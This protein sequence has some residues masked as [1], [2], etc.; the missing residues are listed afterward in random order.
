MTGGKFDPCHEVRVFARVF[1]DAPRIDS[2]RPTALERLRPY[3]RPQFFAYEARDLFR[4]LT[5]FRRERREPAVALAVGKGL[6]WAQGFASSPFDGRD[7][8]SIAA[9]LR[10]E[11]ASG[12][13]WVVRQACAAIRYGTLIQAE[14]AAAFLVKDRPRSVAI[15]DACSAAPLPRRADIARWMSHEVL[16]AAAGWTEIE[17]LGRVTPVSRLLVAVAEH[18]VTSRSEGLARDMLRLLRR[19][20]ASED[21]GRVAASLRALAALGWLPARQ[22][23]AIRLARHRHWIVREAAV[24]T[25][26]RY[27]GPEARE[28]ALA[29]RADP[30]EHVR[31]AALQALLRL[32][33]RRILTL[34]RHALSDSNDRVTRRATAILRLRLGAERMR[35]QFLL[36]LLREHPREPER[37]L[38][39]GWPRGLGLELIRQLLRARDPAVRCRA[40]SLWIA[41]EGDPAALDP[42][43]SDP[44]GTV[45][46]AALN[47]R[48]CSLPEDARGALI[49][50][51]LEDP[52]P[53]TRRLVVEKWL[54]RGEYTDL[55]RLVRAMR[56]PAE[57]VRGAAL[58]RLEDHVRRNPRVFEAVLEA[59]ADPDDYLAEYARI[60]VSRVSLSRGSRW[61]SLRHASK[62]SN[63]PPHPKLDRVASALAWGAAAGRDL[64]QR[65]IRIVALH[66]GLGRTRRASKGG[67]IT[68]EVCL[69]PIFDDHPQAEDIVRG[70]ILHELGHHRYDFRSR[71][72]RSALGIARRE[73]LGHLYGILLDARLE[74]RLRA[75]NSEWA[76]YID[77][78]NAYAFREV[79]LQQPVSAV[80]QSLGGP[81][82]R[83]AADLPSGT[84]LDIG[85]ALRIPGLVSSESAFLACLMTGFNPRLVANARVRRA[86]AAVPPNLKDLD[87]A[88]L[89][90]VARRVARALGGVEVIERDTARVRARMATLGSILGQLA[91]QLEQLRQRIQDANEMLLQGG[92]QTGSAAARLSRVGGPAPGSLEPP[93]WKPRPRLA[94]R[95]ADASYDRLPKEERLE[96]DAARNAAEVVRIFPHVRR[97]RAALLQLV[98]RETE[99]HA[100]RRG[101]RLDVSRIR[102]I[103]TPGELNVLVGRSMLPRGGYLGVLI[104]RS[105][106]MEGEGIRL[107]RAFGTL[108]AEA[109]R[110]VPDLVGHVNAFDHDTFVWL[111]DFRRHAIGSLEAGGGNNDAGGLDRAA[112]LSRA[113][114][115]Q[116]RA[117]VMISD[118]SPTECSEEALRALVERLEWEEGMVCV[119]VLV[120]RVENP[121]FR[122][123]VDLSACPFDEAVTRFAGLI[124]RITRSWR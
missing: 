105:G 37:L 46:H 28:L 66:A 111:G 31:V 76:R 123:V 11:A 44:S 10:L 50:R 120:Y 91:R 84:R 32:A 64:L 60:T 35:D 96:P 124:L 38:E 110:G 79:E 5:D 59:F 73:G 78:L 40:I 19:W 49:R 54:A 94:P 88:A 92:R 109:A 22:R 23:Q 98:H 72:A 114:G 107:A 117:L 57:L 58:F 122:N 89:L 3:F 86:V 17:A 8:E 7:A 33:P 112:S 51:A 41:A 4:D 6:S 9:A 80:A 95:G 25:L 45:R 36:A 103:V 85:T 101:H 43:L 2:R 14:G 100:S 27:G 12:E 26:G 118:G 106:S 52:D 62:P 70:L 63:W 55:D 65:E 34:A 74:R 113:S 83:I 29:M 71:G 116:Q 115:K 16:E 121:C 82:A 67:D 104:D 20:L 90:R 102:R 87:H 75:R 13:Q 18:A 48:L 77:R 39:A 21:P 119:Q 42:L 1:D 69:H 99:E 81:A 68:I 61:S 47:F 56:D 53:D 97:L 30:D 93:E 108:V 15:A 24:E